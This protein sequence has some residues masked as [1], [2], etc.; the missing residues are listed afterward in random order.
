MKDWESLNLQSVTV[1]MVEHFVELSALARL[2]Y[3]SHSVFL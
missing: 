1:G 3:T 2:R